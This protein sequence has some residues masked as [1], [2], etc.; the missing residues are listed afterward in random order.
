MLWQIAV[1]TLIDHG[2]FI[3]ILLVFVAKPGD[4][5]VWTYGW[6][7]HTAIVVGPSDKSHFKCVEL[8]LLKQ[9]LYSEMN[10]SK[11]L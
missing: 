7:G 4:I 2:K 8:K 1:N 9:R 11:P 5:A 3:E 10:I 6:A